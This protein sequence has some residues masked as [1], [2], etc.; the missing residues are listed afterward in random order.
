MTQ[1]ITWDAVG[2][3]LFEV[4]VDRGVFYAQNPTTGLYPLGVAWNGL[5]GVSEKPSGGE[6]TPKYADNIKYANIL[7]MEEYAGSIEAFTYPD[8][9]A[10]SDGSVEAVAGVVIGQQTRK[11]F[12]LSYRTLIG[13]DTEGQSHGYKLHLVYGCLVS[14]SER[15]HQT[16]NETA[17]PN[18]FSWEFTTTAV[19]VAGEKPTSSLTIDSTKVTLADLEALEAILYGTAPS[20]AARLPLPDEVITLMA[21]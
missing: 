6:A 19:A 2:E 20:T 4:G 11:P 9:F 15:S 16:I 8:E 5:V 7:G 10:E 3:K 18:T 14:P 13:N 21:P 12:G 17:E 1:L